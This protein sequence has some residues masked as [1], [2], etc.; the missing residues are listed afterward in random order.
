MTQRKKDILTTVCFE[1][2]LFFGKLI[3]LLILGFFVAL[4]MGCAAWGEHPWDWIVSLAVGSGYSLFAILL[5]VGLPFWM[6]VRPHCTKFWRR[7]IVA[8]LTAY[9]IAA[10]VCWDALGR[11]GYFGRGWGREWGASRIASTLCAPLNLPTVGVLLII[12]K[13]VQGDAR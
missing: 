7:A 6:Y 12:M 5:L 13:C 2:V 4:V 10:M 9:C 11:G 8:A 3:V 1:I